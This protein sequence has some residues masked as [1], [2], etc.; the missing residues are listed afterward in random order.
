MIEGKQ[1]DGS[2]IPEKL[3]RKRIPVDVWG[4]NHIFIV[5]P[6]E[7]KL[8]V[9]VITTSSTPSNTI[10]P[11]LALLNVGPFVNVPLLLPRLKSVHVVPL[12]G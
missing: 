1:K 3:R 4:L 11:P 2:V 10:D 12:P 7:F 9:G 6:S 8:T 5:N